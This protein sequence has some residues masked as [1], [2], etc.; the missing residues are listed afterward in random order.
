M[1]DFFIYVIP[2]SKRKHEIFYTE[3]QIFALKDA[4]L[5]PEEWMDND[6]LKILEQKLLW[7]I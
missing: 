3:E 5:L 2:D 6:E 7:A 4:L 1:A